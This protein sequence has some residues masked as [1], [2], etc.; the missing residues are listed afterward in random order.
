MTETIDL[1]RRSEN[2]K[3]ITGKDTAPKTQMAG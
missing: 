3:H 1:A 2:M